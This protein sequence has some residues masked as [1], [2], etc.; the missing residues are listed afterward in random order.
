MGL[1]T[2]Y[3]N[4]PATIPKMQKKIPIFNKYTSISVDVTKLAIAWHSGRLDNNGLAL[5]PLNFTT[6]GLLIFCSSNSPE[7]SKHPLLI[8][9]IEIN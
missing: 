4:R 6:S 1:F 8:V 9:D 2:K 7:C 5:L 3:T